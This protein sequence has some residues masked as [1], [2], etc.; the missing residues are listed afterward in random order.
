MQPY[1]YSKHKNPVLR[2]IEPVISN[3]S[4]I[5]IDEERISDLAE[6]IHFKRGPFANT[7]LT[8]ADW[9]NIIPENLSIEDAV[10]YIFGFI[11]ID[12]RHWELKEDLKPGETKIK[13]FYATYNNETDH[14]S[15]AM[16]LLSKKAVENGT[17]LFSA[18]Y[19]SNISLDKTKTLFTGFDK[20]NHPMIIPAIEERT[21]IMHK[22]GKH[23]LEHYDGSF[24]N[25]LKESEGYAFFNGNGLVERLA[26]EFSR[27]K[28]TYTYENSTVE[29]YK[30]AQLTVQ[31]LHC[32]LGQYGQLGEYSIKDLDTI[33]VCADYQLPRQ[34]RDLNVLTYSNNLAYTVDNEEL[35]EKNSLKELEI[36]ASAVYAAQLLRDNI[37][38][39][40][41]D[42]ELQP[43]SSLEIDYFLW[44][45]GRLLDL[46]KSK[47]HLTITE[48]Y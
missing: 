36:R 7:E 16:A 1:K 31:A 34:L 39:Y 40:R 35:I 28:D 44:S 43:I 19:M 5:T 21:E 46:D 18:E 23:L 24:Y 14:G 11:T 12:F 33:T 25:L 17:P 15:G 30:L 47:H 22:V 4:H 45:S 20:D 10:N 13:K 48:M 8:I 3:L 38:S 37:N 2:S 9:E 29:I 41:L 32:A 42:E 26:S 27:F 6:Q